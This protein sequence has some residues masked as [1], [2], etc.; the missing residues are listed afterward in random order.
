MRNKTEKIHKEQNYKGLQNVADT[1]E[2]GKKV[3]NNKHR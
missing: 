2:T 3:K 1:T